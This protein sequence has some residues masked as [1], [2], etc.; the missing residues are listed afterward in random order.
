M[1]ICVVEPQYNQPNIAGRV[2]LQS[3]FHL[4]I[5]GNVMGKEM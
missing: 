3:I 2:V 5:F 1:D 4:S